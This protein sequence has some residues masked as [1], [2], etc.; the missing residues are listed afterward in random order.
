MV[1]SAGASPVLD[2]VEAVLQSVLA[3]TGGVAAVAFRLLAHRGG[4]RV[5]E[6]RGVGDPRVDRCVAALHGRAYSSVAG[7]TLGDH[8]AG[9]GRARS[10]G[11]AGLLGGWTA[12]CVDLGLTSAVGMAIVKGTRAVGVVAVLGARLGRGARA[13]LESHHDALSEALRREV[14]R[15][16][17]ALAVRRDQVLL[18]GC[19]AGTR[20]LS[21]RRRRA[22]ALEIGQR[23]G[24]LGGAHLRL[25]ACDQGPLL[26]AVVIAEPC[27]LPRVPVEALLSANQRTVARYASAGATMA[28]TG[29]A[30]GISTE[31]ARSHLKA[32]YR[33]LDVGSRVELAAA[34]REGFPSWTELGGSAQPERGATLGTRPGFPAAR[35]GRRAARGR[36]SR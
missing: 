4:M 8:L 1:Q 34:L 17:F 36:R 5:D 25:L 16:S 26:T 3:D 31:T 13:G 15:R 9:L 19:D 35:S 29:R 22:L 27:A 10:L 12:P 33:R 24:V 20:W 7:A 23:E 30:M 11:R 14:P 21:R 2:P 18:P 6:P 28:E 32:V